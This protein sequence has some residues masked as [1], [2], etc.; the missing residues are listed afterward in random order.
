MKLGGARLIDEGAKSLLRL[1]AKA[2]ADRIEPPSKLLVVTAT[3]YGYDRPDG[4]AVAPITAIG[5]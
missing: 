4:V 1:R 3:G 2:V 5:P